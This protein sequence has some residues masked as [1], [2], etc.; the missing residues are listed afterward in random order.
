MKK[1]GTTWIEEEQERNQDGIRRK[2]LP[3]VP[4][5]LWEGGFFFGFPSLSNSPASPML[6]LSPLHH[7]EG[8]KGMAKGRTWGFWGGGV[9]GMHIYIQRGANFAV[10][11]LIRIVDTHLNLIK[12]QQ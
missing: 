4:M 7:Q 2:R 1:K 12:V 9:L 8:V 5:T 3:G 11:Y 10:G 6:S